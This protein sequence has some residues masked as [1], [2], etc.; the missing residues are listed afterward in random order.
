LPDGTHYSE[1]FAF[2]RR[3]REVGGKVFGYNAPVRHVG[4]IE[5]AALL[6]DLTASA[7][8]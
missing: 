1:D 4:D 7:Q 8:K 6:S 5:Y 2:C 3:W